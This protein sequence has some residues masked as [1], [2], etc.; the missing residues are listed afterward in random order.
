[1]LNV[2]DDNIGRLGNL[3]FGFV[4]QIASELFMGRGSIASRQPCPR[5]RQRTV[6]RR[7]P[8]QVADEM[9]SVDLRWR[10]RLAGPASQN[11]LCYEL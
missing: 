4:D 10:D 6:F 11:S 5:R 9:S 1:M 8:Y 7:Y 2:Q 3:R